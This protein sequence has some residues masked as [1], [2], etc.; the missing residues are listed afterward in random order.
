VGVTE[1]QPK[2]IVF[3]CN[4]CSYTSADLAG[5]NRYKYPESVN[6][7]RFM[8]SGRIEPEFIMK[9]F[10]YGADGVMV[11]GCKLDECHYISGNFRAKERIETTQKLLE[12]VGIGSGRLDTQWISA[13]EGE[14]FAKTLCEFTEKI[15]NLG[16]NPLAQKKEG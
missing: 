5:I 10:E 3:S 2:I 9:T 12:M 15:Q 14:K 11:T 6:I 4:W 13:A 1:F 7:V 16:P 8:C